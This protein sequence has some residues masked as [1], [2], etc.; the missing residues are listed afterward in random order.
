MIGTPQPLVSAIGLPLQPFTQSLL[1]YQPA[2]AYPDCGHIFAYH[3]SVG[4]K[5]LDECH[6][7]RNRSESG[8][9]RN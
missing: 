6:M 3:S 5:E 1:S 9:S 4:S 8:I 7:A 2:T